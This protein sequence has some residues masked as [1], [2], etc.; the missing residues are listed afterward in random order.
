MRFAPS[1]ELREGGGRQGARRST[2]VSFARC[3][4]AR[5]SPA[6][7]RTSNDVSQRYSAESHGDANCSAAPA[8]SSDTLLKG[9][10]GSM[11]VT[12]GPP[13]DARARRTD[14][15]SGSPPGGQGAA[16]P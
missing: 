11:A 6:C 16:P 3:R 12:P 10:Q 9:A 5:A 8:L 13:W 7:A 1:S 2:C 4:R 14:G 15:A